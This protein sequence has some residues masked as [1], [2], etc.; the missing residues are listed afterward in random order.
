[1]T[2]R[3]VI[4]D[5]LRGSPDAEAMLADAGFGDLP[6]EMFGQALAS[7]ADTAP[8]AEADAL[9]PV[10]ISLE[11]GDAGDVFAALEEHAP[12]VLP[13]ESEPDLSLMFA[14]AG[15]IDALD[16]VIDDFGVTV[17][18]EPAEDHL[19]GDH[20]TDDHLD[21]EDATEEGYELLDEDP[22]RSDLESVDDSSDSEAFEDLFETEPEATGADP[23]DLDLDF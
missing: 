11:T 17:E 12:Q 18:S 8:M 6:A 22:F 23:S 13:T 2:L 3:A 7:Y 16:E 1:M 5:L 19:D 14:S 4:E 15:S 9:T 10:L 21:D 20:L